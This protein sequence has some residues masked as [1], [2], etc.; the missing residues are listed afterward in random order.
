MQYMFDVECFL[1]LR[2]CKVI[3]KLLTTFFRLNPRFLLD[4]QPKSEAHPNSHCLLGGLFVDNLL[5]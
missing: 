3:A 1:R 5:A 4:L 2:V